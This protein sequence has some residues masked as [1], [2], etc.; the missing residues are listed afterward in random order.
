MQRHYSAPPDM[1]L[2][3]CSVSGWAGLLG[4][5]V[6]VPVSGR[7]G[8]YG[9]VSG[10]RFSRDWLDDRVNSAALS[11]GA[12]VAVQIRGR[13]RGRFGGRYMRPFD[14][15]YRS[16]LEEDLE[17]TMGTIGLSYLLGR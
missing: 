15:E 10:G 9:E 14:E 16:L 8:A 3:R 4:L 7:M 5:A 12:G 1:T 17:Y 13:F 2:R 6:T 11:V